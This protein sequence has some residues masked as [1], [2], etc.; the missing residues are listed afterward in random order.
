MW[1]LQTKMW[2]LLVSKRQS[3]EEKLREYIVLVIAG[4]TK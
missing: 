4:K 2:D 1:D 3:L